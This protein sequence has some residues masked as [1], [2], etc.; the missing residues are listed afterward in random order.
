MLKEIFQTYR[1]RFIFNFALI[2]IESGLSLLF[3]LFIG[4]AIDS[5]V[6]GESSGAMQLGGLGILALIFGAGRRFFDTRFYAKVF[7]SQGSAILSRIPDKDTST[8]T[9]R[10][11]MLRELV[12]FFEQSIPAIIESGIALIGVIIIIASLSLPTFLGCLVTR[13]LIAPLYMFTQKR[14]IHYNKGYND[15]LENQVNVI[16]SN[17]AEEIDQHL[18]RTM[19]W[20]IRL[21][22]LETFNFS[23]SWTLLMAFLVVSIVYAA[24][25]GEAQVSTLFVLVMYVFQYI[26]NVVSLPYFYQQWLRLIEIKSRLET[27]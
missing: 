26:E 6:E 20:N 19:R 16:D 27:Y 5:A 23:I 21:S 3:P 9:A 22:D 4:I 13:V 18:K 1:W 11:G 2:L 7:Q 12:E 15:E 17:E 10:L 8:K 24:G 25:A 14:T